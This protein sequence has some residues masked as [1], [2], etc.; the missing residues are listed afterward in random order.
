MSFFFSRRPLASSVRLRLKFSKQKIGIIESIPI[1]PVSTDTLN[2]RKDPSRPYTVSLDHNA[3]SN[4]RTL[5]RAALFRLLQ[6]S[7]WFRGQHK[8]VVFERTRFEN[9]ENLLDIHGDTRYV[10]GEVV[11]EEIGL[12][13]NRAHRA[14]RKTRNR[15]F[16]IGVLKCNTVAAWF[17]FAFRPSSGGP[18][19]SF[20]VKATRICR[21]ACCRF[22]GIVSKRR[23]HARTTRNRAVNNVISS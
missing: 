7:H 14:V 8:R 5:F 20:G 17:F 11:A 3:A 2:R 12:A 13:K 4:A 18:C 6:I 1:V 10:L 22:T 21:V 9:L 19:K 23:R 15:S 16:I